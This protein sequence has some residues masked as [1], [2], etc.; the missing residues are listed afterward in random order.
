MYNL[1]VAQYHQ[2]QY[3]AAR[4]TLLGILRVQSNNLD[5]PGRAF[6]F[7]RLAEVSRAMGEP[8]RAV[9]EYQA[10]IALRSGDGGRDI[11]ELKRAYARV[12]RAL[13]RKEEADLV[14]C[15]AE[16]AL[17]MPSARGLGNAPVR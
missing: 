3:G 17:R 9:R 14:E 4:K 5:S 16:E 7:G 13:G 15:Q 10:A 6:T 8:D 12:L 2:G 1:A 11:A